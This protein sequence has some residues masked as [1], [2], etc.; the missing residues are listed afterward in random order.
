MIDFNPYSRKLLANPHPEYCRLREESPIARNARFGFWTISRYDDVLA[1]LKDWRT[2]SSASGITLASFSGLKPMLILMDPPRHDDLRALLLRAFTPRRVSRLEARIRSVARE[3]ISG[4]HGRGS[5][6]LICEFASPYPT[7]VIAELLGVDVRDRDQFKAWSDA[8]MTSAS[9]EA[10]SLERAYGEIF[11]YFERIVAERRKRPRDDLVSALVGAEASA[12]VSDEEILGFCALLLIA[13]NETMANFLGNAMLTLDRH[14]GARRELVRDSS[15]LRTATD[16][17]LRF[18]PSV[19]ELARTLTR[20]VTLHGE[21]LSA[22][23]RVLLMIAAAN[24]DPRRFPAPDRLD[25][26]RTPNPHLSFGF[27]IHFCMGAS[28]ARME[29]R[30]ALEELLAAIPRYRVVEDEISWFRTP[31]VRGPKSLL[32]EFDPD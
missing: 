29:A 26:R 17:L 19:H 5:C 4:F 22:G 18:E 24:R 23:D 8:I 21:T 3:I 10:S 28:L 2:Y 12:G 30:I 13:G 1:A 9:V 6:E 31:A 7:T 16:E 11:S 15:A 25:L 32:L 27:G 14:P 20:D